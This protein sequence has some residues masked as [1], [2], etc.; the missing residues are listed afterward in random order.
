[1][2]ADTEASAALATELARLYD[3]DMEMAGESSDVDLYLALARA[4]EGPVLELAA[5]SGRI[6]V[7][8]AAAGHEVIGVDRDREMLDRAQA[9]WLSARPGGSGSLELIVAEISSLELARRFGL[10]ILAFNSLLLLGGRDEQLAALRTIARHLGPAG[11]AVIDIVLPTPDDLALYDGRLQLAWTRTD[12]ATGQ[13][14]AKLWSARHEPASGVAT[15]DTFFE[16]WPG[17]GGEV[18]R[19]SRRDEMH[20]LGSH[21]LLALAERAGLQALTVGGD[22]EMGPLEGHSPRIVLVAGL[23]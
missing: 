9:A 20:L 13:R 5:G 11:R 22:L 19:L 2:A 12:T 3:M 16:L 18:R 15:I 8:L 17:G 10:V 1:M 7:P 6:C 23:L 4:S 14:V 21:E